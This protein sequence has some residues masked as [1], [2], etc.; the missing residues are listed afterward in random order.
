MGRA[1]LT[2]SWWRRLGYH[3]AAMQKVAEA[4]RGRLQGKR[5]LLTGAASGI[6]RATALLFAE[7]VLY[8]ASD[9]SSFMT[10]TP[11]LID[12]GFTAG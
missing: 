5:A 2:S 9:A 4:G 11:L 12:G 1:E 7:A 10:G 6:G 3:P 8:L